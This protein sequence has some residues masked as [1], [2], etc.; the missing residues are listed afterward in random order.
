MGDTKT[1]LVQRLGERPASP[2][3]DALIARCA[4]GEFHCFESWH[5]TPKVLLVGELEALGFHDLAA[6][7]K[8]GEFDEPPPRRSRG[9]R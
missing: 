2:A 6:L 9:P 7:V 8:D 1:T 4:R 3:R 5:A